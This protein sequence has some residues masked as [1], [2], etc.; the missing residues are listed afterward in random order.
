MDQ[1]VIWSFKCK[2][3]KLLLEF[4]ISEAD[5][6][7]ERKIMDNMHVLQAMRF[8][9]HSW[10]AVHPDVIINAFRKAGFS[11][12][13]EKTVQTADECPLV[14]NFLQYVSIDDELFSEEMQQVELE[15]DSDEVSYFVRY[16]LML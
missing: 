15:A 4:V 1:G 16:Q 7:I 13:P 2:F 12:Q 10:D 6:G 3:R 8:V 9:R 5:K 14:E 11:N